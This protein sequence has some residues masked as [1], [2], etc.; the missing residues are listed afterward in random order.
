MEVS[1]LE[2]LRIKISL[3]SYK[4][5]CRHG[6]STNGLSAR[7]L[8]QTCRSLP[9]KMRQGQLKPLTS[10]EVFAGHFHSQPGFRQCPVAHDRSGR[11]SEHFSRFFDGQAAKEPQFE[12]LALSLVNRR[13]SLKRVIEGHH[14]R[15]AR[16]RYN[17]RFVERHMAGVPSSL[18][19]M[20]LFGVVNQ[21]LSHQLGRNSQ[22]LSP[23]LP[24]HIFLID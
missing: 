13:Q 10:L 9:S 17:D 14:F 16:W 8:C 23:I 2:E 20:A 4:Y 5:F 18:D 24:A 19:P 1:L 12:N 7:P 11:H 3:V 22:E 6:T 21:N 15:R